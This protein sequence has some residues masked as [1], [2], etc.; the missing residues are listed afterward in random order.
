MTNCKPAGVLI[1]IDPKLA[2]EACDAYIE[3]GKKAVD[4]ARAIRNAQIDEWYDLRE[5]FIETKMHWARRRVF[6]IFSRKITREEALDS[7][8]SKPLDFD[9][10]PKGRYHWFGSTPDT[11]RALVDAGVGMPWVAKRLLIAAELSGHAQFQIDSHSDEFQ[12]IA[13]H[14]K[15]QKESA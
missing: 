11:G 14:H 7:Y 12:I 1:Y 6:F 2:I 8:V 13:W 3:Y 9:E 15:H 10:R 4:R 5:D